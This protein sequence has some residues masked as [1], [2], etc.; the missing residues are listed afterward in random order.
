MATVDDV[1]LPNSGRSNN[2]L[3]NLKLFFASQPFSTLNQKISRLSAALIE[4]IKKEFTSDLPLPLNEELSLG[5]DLAS[6]LFNKGTITLYE[7]EAIMPP[8]TTIEVEEDPHFCQTY[9]D[10]GNEILSKSKYEALLNR[11]EYYDMFIDGF[12]G[13]VSKKNANNEIVKDILT[14][15]ELDL[16][17]AYI[18][19]RKNVQPNS[20]TKNFHNSALAA[21]KF[22]EVARRKVDIPV[23]RFEYRAFTRDRT[24]FG[25][26]KKF[27]F[28]PPAFM[29]Y[30]LIVSYK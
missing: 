12:T 18:I 13:A 9:T 8:E 19:T 21:L 4:T 7:P 11:A 22:F 14:P 20:I 16:I 17:S 6:M 10:S 2:R 24:T 25:I 1:S 27:Q 30:C 28:N 3:N 23:S 5:F 15:W 26:N 29:T